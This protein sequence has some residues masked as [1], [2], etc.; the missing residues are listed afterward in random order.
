MLKALGLGAVQPTLQAASIEAVSEKRRGAA[1][2]TY[3]LGTDI[4]QSA[5]PILGGITAD[6]IGYSGMFMIFALPLLLT[7]AIC[8]IH[9][10]LKG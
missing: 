3:Y 4:G 1:S 9:N 6:A 7:G 8:A 10:K 5:A 2:A